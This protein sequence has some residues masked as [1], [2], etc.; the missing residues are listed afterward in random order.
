[1]QDTDRPTTGDGRAEAVL[2]VGG[3]HW[4]SDDILHATGYGDALVYLETSEKRIV[5]TYPADRERA[6]LLAN[7]D[8][9][10]VD[11]QLRGRG[12]SGRFEPSPEDTLTI[13]LE[14]VRRAGVG[15][16]LVSRRFPV[17]T[18]E[19]LRGHGVSVHVDDG[20]IDA[21]R[22]RKSSHE[23]EAIA[24]ALRAAEA[25]L[26]HART[27]LAA[28]DVDGDGLRWQ[29]EPLTSERLQH[30]VL[31]F[32]AERGFEGETPV[33]AGGAQGAVINEAGQ[34]ILH[35]REPIL[36]DLFPRHRGLRYFA[37]ISRVFCVGKPPGKLRVV[38]AAVRDAL[39]LARGLARPGA[40]GADMYRRVCEL[41]R[42][43]GFASPL[44]P[45]DT[46]RTSPGPAVARFLGHGIGLGLHEYTTGP[47]PYSNVPLEAGDVI[48]LEPTLYERGWGAVR[49]EDMVL[50]TGTGCQTLTEYD[51]DLDVGT[52][53]TDRIST[54]GRQ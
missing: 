21:R 48:T 17:A 42:E 54:H 29:G 37:D 25:S 50:I 46:S 24:Q 30:E 34:G 35:A 16:V 20:A 51:Y 52:S 4:T 27:I 14:T 15:S 32:W 10:W 2:M 7:V 36:F 19:H 3:D 40:C 11:S 47:F 38:H 39:D 9:V 22:R 31:A 44:F 41:L 5:V 6:R 23:V 8:E 28:A 49:L 12:R 53:A 18:A 43:R 13:A 45:A 33:I 1:M 26:T